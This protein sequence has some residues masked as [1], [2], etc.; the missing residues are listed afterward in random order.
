MDL[1]HPWAILSGV[2]IGMIGFVVFNYGRKQTNLKCI[3]TGGVLCV[4]PYFVGSTLL[5]WGIA[6]ACLGGLYAWTR[7]D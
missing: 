6:A 4:F 7:G 3:A 2:L 5:M 1:S